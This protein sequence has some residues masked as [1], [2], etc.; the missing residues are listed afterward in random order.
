[1]IRILHIVH[2]ITK[3]GGL[4]NMIMNYYRFMDRTQIQFDFLYFKDS[5]DTFQ[6]EIEAMGGRCYRISEPSV[7]LSFFKERETFFKQHEG[8][9][10]A[11]H[12]HAL[13]ASAVFTKVAKRRGVIHSHSHSHNV[14]YGKGNP[15]KRLRNSCFIHQAKVL[16]DTHL[17]CSK[18]AAEFMYGENEYQSGKAII[19]KNAIDL[20][21][22]WFNADLRK[23]ARLGLGVEDKL[24]IGHVGGL[25]HQKN[26]SFLIDIFNDFQKKNPDSVLLL[27]GGEGIAAGSTKQLL[28]E[29]IE[30]YGITDKVRFL[31]LRDDVNVIYQAL[32]VFV[33]PSLF[34]GL[35]IVLVEAQASGLPCIVSPAVPNEARVLA[36][37]VSMDNLKN[38]DSWV[39]AI[40]DASK[41]DTT[42]RY[43]E[44]ELFDAYNIKKQCKVLEN[45]YLSM[46]GKD[47]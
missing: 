9:W 4:C 41:N 19:I 29:K 14:G 43:V 11:I 30:R 10:K 38:T 16:G 18:D 31:G 28:I 23:K 35:G 39:N 26:H 1:M 40:E 45:V 7:S 33:F 46:S 25:A 13:F 3:G 17:A 22:Y 21:K 5:E 15:L 42:Q 44:H 27:I 24:V 32:D 6:T 12:C 2:A 47:L 20:D 34:E 36:S 8:E 37:Y